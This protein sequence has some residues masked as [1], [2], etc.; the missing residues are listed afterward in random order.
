MT[1]P[2]TNMELMISERNLL[3]LLGQFLRFHIDFRV[4]MNCSQWIKQLTSLN[5]REISRKFPLQTSLAMEIGNDDRNRCAAAPILWHGRFIREETASI[6]SVLCLPPFM[7][8]PKS[9]WWT[10]W[11][12]FSHL[13][14][15]PASFSIGTLKKQSQHCTQLLSNSSALSQGVLRFSFQRYTCWETCQEFIAESSTVTLL[16][17]GAQSKHRNAT[18]CAKHHEII[19]KN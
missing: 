2:K 9:K 6:S 16:I 15:L 8:K 13:P 10:E 4:R 18:S 3:F 11:S 7:M 12:A 17:Q 1:Q 5:V 19:P 14:N